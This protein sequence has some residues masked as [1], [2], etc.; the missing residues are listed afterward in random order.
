MRER[1]NV[2]IFTRWKIILIDA[3]KRERENIL[4]VHSEFND[5]MICLY[6]VSNNRVLFDMLFE[7]NCSIKG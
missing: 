3:E 1:I 6:H 5:M 2:E 7:N 4:K